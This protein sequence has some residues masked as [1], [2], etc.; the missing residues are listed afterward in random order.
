M[1]ATTQKIEAIS[2]GQLIGKALYWLGSLAALTLCLV[3]TG[4]FFGHKISL[5]GHTEDRS[6]REIVI[7][8]N[9]LHIPANMIRFNRQRRDG[10][11]ERVDLYLHWPEM[12]GYSPDLE[13]DFND[14]GNG[15]KLLFLA[16]EARQATHDMSGRY[17]PVYLPLTEGPGEPGPATLKV[18]RFRS[19]SGFVDEE[20][21]ASPQHSGK[22][23]FVARCLNN[24][25]SQDI[26]AA[27]QRDVFV[28][29]DLQLTYRFP[30]E[31]LK[32]WQALD[33]AIMQFAL[34]HIK[35]AE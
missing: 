1:Q 30:R 3:I 34:G 16:F 13:N 33:M 28:G 20:L 14:A 12:Q 17:G 32:D 6:I 35:S 21:L 19:D 31:L 18:Q 25:S 11:A 5:G 24:N 2:P 23:P 8:D 10:V 15:K 22:Q 4:Y 26:L 9:V 29:S 7:G 27:C